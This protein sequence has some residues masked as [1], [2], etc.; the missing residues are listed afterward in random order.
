[1]DKLLHIIATPRHGSSRTLK[2]SSAFLDAF[3]RTHPDWVVETIDLF[4][5]DLPPLY[6]RRVDGRYMLLS[7]GELFGEMRDAW[8]GILYQIDRFK[9]ASGYLISTPMWNFNIPYRL[10]HYIDMIVQPTHLFR[11]SGGGVEGLAGGRMVVVTS[12]G[13]EYL[14]EDQ[15][16]LDFQEPYLRAIF[17]FIGITDITFVIAQPMDTGTKQEKDAIIENACSRARDVAS[18]F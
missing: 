9:S 5:E 13:G 3:S 14:T 16:A 17:G 11:Y 12:R 10:K 7:G 15:R 1:M 18:G 8:E 6:V 2:V 4:E